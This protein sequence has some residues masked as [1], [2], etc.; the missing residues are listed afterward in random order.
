MSAWDWTWIGITAGGLA[1]FGIAEAR[2]LQERS[3]GKPG[4]TYSAALRRWGGIEPAK[5]WRFIT[6]PAFLGALA[7]FGLHI[8]TPYL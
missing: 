3:N 5:W 2:A 8:T 6:I 4:G 1:A 7:L